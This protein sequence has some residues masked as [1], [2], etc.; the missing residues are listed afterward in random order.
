MLGIGKN[1]QFDDKKWRSADVEKMANCCLQSLCI[2][3]DKIILLKFEGYK[4]KC[5]H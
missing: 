2:T 5:N 4:A 3:L 1:V